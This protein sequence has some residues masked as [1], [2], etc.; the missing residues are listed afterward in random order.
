MMLYLIGIVFSVWVLFYG[1][2]ERLENTVFGYFEFGSAAEKAVLIKVVAVITL[3]TSL[4]LLV[5]QL[6]S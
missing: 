4:A 6:A 1:G 3:L 2:A 5:Y